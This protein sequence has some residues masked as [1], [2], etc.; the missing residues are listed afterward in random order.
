M[1]IL[2]SVSPKQTLVDA[3][4]APDASA[5]SGMC[6]ADAIFSHVA[7]SRQFLEPP[8]AALQ[9]GDNGAC[10]DHTGFDVV[11]KPSYLD[12]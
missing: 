4:V 3:A 2:S 10:D 5:I 9:V 6:P 1:L 12:V 8:Q 11:L 7:R